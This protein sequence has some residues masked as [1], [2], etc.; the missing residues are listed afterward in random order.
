[1]NYKSFFW[2]EETKVFL[3]M[4]CRAEHSWITECILC[5]YLFSEYIEIGSSVW[6]E[7]GKL[8][9]PNLLERPGGDLSY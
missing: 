2:P 5:F 7:T 6:G 9:G 8:G 3:I 1:M 4:I